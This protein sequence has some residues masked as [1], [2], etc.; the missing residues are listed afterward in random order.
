MTNK[1][2]V[3]HAIDELCQT[4]PLASARVMATRLLTH[5]RGLSEYEYLIEPGKKIPSP[6]LAVL[7]KALS[8][9]LENRP[10]Q[11]VLGTEEFCGHEFKVDERVLIPRPETEQLVRII[12]EDSNVMGCSD[13][14]ILDAC[15]GSGCIALSLAAALPKAQVLACD[16]SED[17]LDLAA[18]QEIF[19]DEGRHQRLSNIPEWFVWDVL[20]EPEPSLPNMSELDVFVSNPP[21]ICESE[22]D[23]MEDNVLLYEPG[24]ALFVPD[25]DPLRFYRALGLRAAE[26]LRLGGKGYFEINERYPNEV[27]ALL[28]EQGFSEVCAHEDYHGKSRFVSFVKYFM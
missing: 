25:N 17:A 6:E 11:Y 28:E 14:K 16:I 27:C 2:F 12:V 9:L 18:S 20:T 1:E 15:T 26:L 8:E 10:L 5:F 7:E 13:P 24:L 19:L 23:F 22:K 21:Y 3:T 4:F